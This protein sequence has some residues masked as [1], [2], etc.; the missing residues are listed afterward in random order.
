MSDDEFD[1]LPNSHTLHTLRCRPCP[2]PPVRRPNEY[3]NANV[4]FI[5]SER[6]RKLFTTDVLPLKHT[7]FFLKLS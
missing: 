7:Q 2:G 4:G 5:G 1:K 6:S 3:S